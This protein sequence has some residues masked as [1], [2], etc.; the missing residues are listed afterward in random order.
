MP[1]HCL[2]G[3]WARLRA[4]DIDDWTI[5][6][7][8]EYQLLDSG[9]GRKLERIAGML[10]V[11][12]CVQA[13][14]RPRL[15]ESEWKKASSIC[16]RTK[17]GGG[18]WEH[19]RGEPDPRVFRWDGEAGRPLQV[20]MRLTSFGHC[21]AFF[22]QVSLW[23]YFQRA[24]IQSQSERLSFLNL[25][26]YTGCASVAAALTGA[27]VYHVD[28]SKGSSV[29]G[30]KN[31]EL[32]DIPQDHI[33]WVHEDARDFLAFSQKR[34]FTYTGVYLD[35]PAWGHGKKQQKW[36][37]EEHCLDLLAAAWSVVAPGG[38]MLMSTHTPGVQLQALRSMVEDVAGDGRLVG[39]GALGVEHMHDCRILPAG[40]YVLAERPT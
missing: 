21:G 1:P 37:F 34:G 18:Q 10:V 7:L 2:Y 35:P 13:L 36:V 5:A 33:R 39:G 31:Q 25:F 40:Y 30:K 11:R 20:E 22:E 19:K 32:S 14:W 29:L 16:H 17:D 26:G 12:P 4:M 3:L 23:R 9:L 28:S 15:P 27:Q 24:L 8:Q 38:F 6:G